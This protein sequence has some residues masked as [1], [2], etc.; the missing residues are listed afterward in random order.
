MQTSPAVEQNEN[1]KG[2]IVRG[3]S[4]VGE[5]KVY[6]EKYLQYIHLYSPSNGSMNEKTYIRRKI[7]NKKYG[8]KIKQHANV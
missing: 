2:P 3:I 6:G 4:P 1:I 8:S 5:K 7:S